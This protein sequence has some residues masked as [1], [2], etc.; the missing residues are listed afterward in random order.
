MVEVRH[1]IWGHRAAAKRVPDARHSFEAEVRAIARLH[2]PHVVTLLDQ[3]PGP[4]PWMVMELAAGT[5]GPPGS[6]DQLSDILIAV[7]R[8]LAVAHAAD[9][10]H[11][12]VKPSNV[13][14]RP[15]GS[16][17]LA[18]FGL[19]RTG[20]D[21]PAPGGGSVAFMAPE[22]FDGSPVGPAADLYSVG[23]VA[24]ALATGTPPPGR[25][26]PFAP[27]FPVPAGLEGWV[28]GLLAPAA[29]RPD[30]ASQAAWELQQLGRSTVR[31]PASAVTVPGGDTL[32]TALTGPSSQ[33]RHEATPGTHPVP[34]EWPAAARPRRP[35]TIGIG[36][37]ELWAPPLV[38][39]D[40]LRRRLW[41][42]LLA[43]RGT[44]VVL[45][46][47]RSGRVARGWGRHSLMRPRRMSGRPF[48]GTGGK[49]SA[50]AGDGYSGWT[51]TQRSMSTSAMPI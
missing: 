43:P 42:A 22:R 26:A 3:G 1:R 31:V 23:C 49:R 18:D 50:P 45:H 44:L 14:V 29:Q 21:D 38:G 7:L 15:D 4:P 30:R 12:D 47:H 16:V 46:G 41:D 48:S 37:V 24:W 34:L 11:L 28:R 9:V 33:V 2:D 35:E 39:R 17:A 20:T 40:G 25:E 32:P 5:V 27:G 13:L 19:S 51:M 10:L 6:F 36:L 8:A